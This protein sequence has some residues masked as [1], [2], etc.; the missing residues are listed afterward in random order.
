MEEVRR[1]PLFLR[2]T[3]NSFSVLQLSSAPDLTGLTI[4]GQN[5]GA[6]V[7]V[8]GGGAFHGWWTAFGRRKEPAVNDRK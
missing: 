7:R 8:G 1:P 3:A 4:H 5:G 2:T 6:W